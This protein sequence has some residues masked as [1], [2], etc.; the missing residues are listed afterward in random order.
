MLHYITAITM[1]Y[2]HHKS[3]LSL[4]PETERRKER[5]KGRAKRCGETTELEGREPIINTLPRLLWHPMELCEKERRKRVRRSDRLPGHGEPHKLPGSMNA[6]QEYMEPRA[7]KDRVCISLYD[8]E[9]MSIYPGAFQI[10]TPHRSCTCGNYFSWSSLTISET[11]I[12]A[13]TP[14]THIH[15]M[16]VQSLIHQTNDTDKDC[17][18]N[19][20]INTQRV[21][22]RSSQTL[23]RM[24]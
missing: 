22:G 7:G 1:S 19:I 3:T 17:K 8:N 12:K 14:G 21:R 18:D 4:T 9:I 13:P 24:Q 6:R 11:T 5:K 2:H 15:P 16:A 23:Q 20:F 10:Y